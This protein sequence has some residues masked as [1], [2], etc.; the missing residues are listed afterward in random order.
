MKMAFFFYF[1]L[2]FLLIILLCTYESKL[3]LFNSLYV[4]SSASMNIPLNEF[5]L[6]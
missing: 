4:V 5:K 1:L 6:K 3:F 2:F